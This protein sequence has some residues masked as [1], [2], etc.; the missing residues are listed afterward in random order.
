MY[1]GKVAFCEARKKVRRDFSGAAGPY[2][3]AATLKLEGGLDGHQRVQVG[4]DC[5]IHHQLVRNVFKLPD[6]AFLKRELQLHIEDLMKV[7]I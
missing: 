2:K 5:K 1:A 3:S 6:Q 4:S 7:Y